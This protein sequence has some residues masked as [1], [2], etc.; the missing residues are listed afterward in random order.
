VIC[1]T[2]IEQRQQ[3]RLVHEIDR[4][5]PAARLHQEARERVLG[6]P[7]R[8][9]QTLAMAHQRLARE[10]PEQHHAEP[11]KQ[12][13]VIVGDRLLP[14]EP[15]PFQ[16]RMI[17]PGLRQHARRHEAGERREK[18]REP[19]RAQEGQGDHARRRDAVQNPEEDVA[20]GKRD[21]RRDGDEERRAADLGETLEEGCLPDPLGMGQRQ[22]DA[23]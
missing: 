7:A 6:P 11:G 5:A 19:R 18:R 15:E 4:Q 20:L 13:H 17:E 22:A 21:H 1:S 2:P 16:R 9:G 8:E 12:R 3:D 23:D 10:K 14:S